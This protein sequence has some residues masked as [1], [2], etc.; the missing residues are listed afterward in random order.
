MSD[1]R[2]VW[3]NG[4]LIPWDQANVHVLSHGFSRGA[5]VF[6]VFGIHNTDSGPA[7]FRFE[8]H[9]KR[10]RRTVDLLGMKLAQ[11]N[12][13][14]RTAV[15]QTTRV[16]NITKGYIKIM[17]YYGVEAFTTLVPDKMLDLTILAIPAGA[18]LGI[19]LA[20]TMSACLCKWNKLHPGTVPIEAKVS[21]HYLNGFLARQEAMGRG[22][23]IGIMMDTHGFVAEGSIEALFMVKDG[24]IITAPVGRV[25]ASISRQSVIDIARAEGMEVRE[26]DYTPEQLLEADEMFVSATPYKVQGISRIEDK[27]YKDAPGPV[28]QKLSKLLE[29]IYTGQDKRF[30]DWMEA[31]N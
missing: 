16:N 1:N 23:D 6:E 22:F 24:V 14:I 18:D 28:A 15:A 11:S 13:E 3:R 2:K 29:K 5:V 21:A 10:L 20:G 4:K 30:K 17:A 9:L 12:D 31:L 19:D 26:I 8:L 27:E 7:A 25:L